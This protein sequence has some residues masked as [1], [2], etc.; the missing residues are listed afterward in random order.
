M[1]LRGAE[2]S[3]VPFPASKPTFCHAV[4]NYTR[5]YGHGGSD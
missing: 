4:H 3:D 5:E 2:A 1:R